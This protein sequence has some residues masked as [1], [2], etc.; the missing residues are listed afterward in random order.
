MSAFPAAK[1]N[2][3]NTSIA[4]LFKRVTH[5]VKY[6]LTHEDILNAFVPPNLHEISRTVSKEFDLGYRSNIITVQLNS[7]RLDLAVIPRPHT[8][9]ALPRTRESPSPDHPVMQ[10]LA[11]YLESYTQV[12]RQFSLVGRVVEEL[13]SVCTSAQQV[14]SVWPS[15]L[16]LLEQNAHEEMTKY[17]EK[18][19]AGG[20][21]KMPPR[22][23]WLRMATRET[24][25]TIASAQLAPDVE[26][27]P[28]EVSISVHSLP[29][30]DYHGEKITLM[31]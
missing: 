1:M 16:V 10:K 29:P 25:L 31:T 24:A 14:R 19:R 2:H 12:S 9:I 26:Q 8:S 5:H 21:P 20:S 22:P 11:S 30:S 17:V 28:R 4:F 18:L 23:D 15:I 3:I 6:D 13:D 7:G 27:L